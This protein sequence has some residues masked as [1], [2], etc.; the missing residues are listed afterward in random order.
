MQLT[1]EWY[2][3]LSSMGFNRMGLMDGTSNSGND[4]KRFVYGM[5]IQDVNSTFMQTKHI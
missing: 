5:Y 2:L 3:N 4:P 1:D